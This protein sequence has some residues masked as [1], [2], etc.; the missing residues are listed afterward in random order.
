MK[1]SW[2]E[3]KQWAQS[4]FKKKELPKL[5]VPEARPLSPCIIE[6]YVENEGKKE[7]NKAYIPVSLLIR[8]LDDDRMLNIAVA[9]NYGV[10]KSSIINTA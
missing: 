10:G 3:I 6:P 8:A 9:G 7:E 4:V 5:T 1:C 2:T